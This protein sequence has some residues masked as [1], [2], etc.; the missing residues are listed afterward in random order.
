L[1]FNISGGKNINDEF[2]KAIPVQ[3]LGKRED[4]GNTVLYI[5]S[6]AGELLTGTTVIAD[7]GAWLTDENNYWKVKNSPMFK[8]IS[9]M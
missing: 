4:I 1:H 6:P 5:T 3:R 9:K 8:Q 2:V 7:G